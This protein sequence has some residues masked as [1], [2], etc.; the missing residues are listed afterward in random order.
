MTILEYAKAGIIVLGA[1]TNAG[2]VEYPA[3]QTI[4]LMD[5]IARA[6]GFTRLADRK[7]VSITRTTDGKTEKTIYN[8]DDIRDGKAK[9][10]PLKKDDSIYVPESLI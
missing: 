9:D 10:V 5:A 7:K 8:T 6:G 1:V 3:V 2:A 4:S